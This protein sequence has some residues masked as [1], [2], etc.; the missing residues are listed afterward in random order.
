MTADQLTLPTFHAA[1]PPREY[2][3]YDWHTAL[4]DLGSRAKLAT[5]QLVHDLYELL[6]T[7]TIPRYR[8]AT[9]R[10]PVYL[11]L[12]LPARILGPA[13]TTKPDGTCGNLAGLSII[14][15]TRLPMTTFGLAD[16]LC[17]REPVPTAHYRWL[18]DT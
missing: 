16:T 7:D 15:D 4:G 17:P 12:Q 9:G 2:R 3:W 13:W 11:L 10:D 14:N 8:D 6:L 18:S 1:D 5:P